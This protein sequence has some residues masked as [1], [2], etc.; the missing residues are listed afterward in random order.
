MSYRKLSEQLPA[1]FLK[2]LETLL[3]VEER[4]AFLLSFDFKRERALSINRTKVGKLSQELITDFGITG[5]VEWSPNSYYTS[6]DLSELTSS[7][8]YAAG[9][10]Y[11][12]EASATSPASYM[13]LSEGM[14]VLDLAAAPGGKTLQL[15]TALG[16]GGLLLS[17]D[18]SVSRQRA[19]LRNVE[20]YGLSNVV[21]SADSPSKIAKL[22]PQSFDAILVDAPCSGEGMFAKDASYIEAWA[23]D[24]PRRYHELQLSI[25]EDI[26]P[27]LRPG[28]FIMYSTCTFN[29]LENEGTIG[30][31]L[32]R[33]GDFSLEEIE[34]SPSISQG[35]LPHTYRIWP[36]R[37]RGL[38]HFFCKL[39]RVGDAGKLAAE[40]PGSGSRKRGSGQARDMALKL[41]RE[42][43]APRLYEE[44]SGT[45]EY[46]LISDRLYAVS[47]L[48]PDLG[49]L[50]LLRNSLLLAE[51]TKGGFVPSQQLAM[52][53]RAD[54]SARALRLGRDSD[55]LRR[56]LLGETLLEK[57]EEGLVLICLDDYPLGF[58][59]AGGNKLKNLY[60]KDWI[61]CLRN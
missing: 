8:Y 5:P 22:L 4:E 59:K 51:M 57:A 55:L 43:G 54:D 52:F 31:F 60:K 3:P 28:G 2:S 25:L 36:H 24:A 53:M 39:R 18:I 37:A 9:L 41:F 12:Q 34:V 47:K 7:P 58:A 48:A 35:G 11:L 44:L 23:E 1:A 14:R 56:Y 50:R 42:V 29:E 16:R 26:L 19:T 10:F 38:G 40:E 46:E 49:G 17:N 33:H 20:K 32:R 45:H 21:V 61:K 6:R 30:E 27:A 13:G 15:A